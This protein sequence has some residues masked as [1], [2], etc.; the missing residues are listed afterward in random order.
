MPSDKKFLCFYLVRTLDAQGQKV[1]KFYYLTF[2]L[3]TTKGLHGGGR[4]GA[5]RNIEPLD[6]RVVLFGVIKVD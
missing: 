3:V 1:R 5:K 2:N 6:I 4:G